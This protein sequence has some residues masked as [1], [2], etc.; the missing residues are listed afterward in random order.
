MRATGSSLYLVQESILH[1]NSENRV[2]CEIYYDYERNLYA[3][4]INDV[5]ISEHV[6]KEEATKKLH[7]ELGLYVAN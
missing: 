2:K 7:E 6:R 1:P 3:L 4:F 5:C